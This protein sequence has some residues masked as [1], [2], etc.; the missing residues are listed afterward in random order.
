M[1]LLV[2]G[3]LLLLVGNLYVQSQAMQSRI[4]RE[5]SAH[6]KMPAEAR[7]TTLTPWDGL[8]IDGVTAPVTPAATIPSPEVSGDNTTAATAE[9][10]A[11][12]RLVQLKARSFRARLT[13]AAL[14]QRREIVVR[15][16][17]FDAP[18]LSWAQ[19]PDGRW[20]WP[21][22]DAQRLAVAQ[23]NQR[24][25]DLAEG[26]APGASTSAS[27]SPS[28]GSGSS[29]TPAATGSPGA[30]SGTTTAPATAATT[31]AEEPAP[32]AT[33]P[34]RRRTALKAA[35]VSVAIESF[36]V[37]HGT[38][39]FL[40]TRGEVYA[41]FSG[42][43]LDGQLDDPTGTAGH[44]RLW[45]GRSTLR[46]LPTLTKFES[47]FAYSSESLD[48]TEGRG[49][50]AGGVA[51]VEYH[52]RHADPGS[53]FRMRGRLEKIALKELSTEIPPA[54]PRF[55]AGQLDGEMEMS[56]L[57]NTA[58]DRTGKAQLR[59]VDAQ[60]QNL[61]LLQS[62]GD[63]LRIGELS[64]LKFKTAQ[65]DARLEGETLRI[66]PIV[67]AAGS[68]RLEARGTCGLTGNQTLDLQARLIIDRATSRGLSQFI[69]DI[70]TAVENSP[71]GARYIDFRI[72]GP[73]AN[74]RT[75][76]LD[77]AVKS[78]KPLQDLIQT[79]IGGSGG[80]KNKGGTGNPPA[81]SG[82]SGGRDRRGGNREP[83]AAPSASPPPPAAAG[84][85]PGAGSSPAA[86]NT[87][88]GAGRGGGN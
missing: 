67:L 4:R 24:I 15:E 76:L 54:A 77:R 7:K 13:L 82:S 25:A 11:A 72:A 52:L 32:P 58:A 42:V 69:D 85:R 2:A 64:Q 36:R 39:R 21:R 33:R 88:S 86:G 87:G 48:I 73:L 79:Y 56:G 80:K 50:L 49:D 83:A 47:A 68:L 74:P 27:P 63:Y 35:P 81:G 55:V 71:D 41:Q 9:P 62:L 26:R 16:I 14:W 23:E 45:F 8:R 31:P 37:R 19:T 20:R 66:D 28:S 34:A 3:G 40:D 60:L 78:A 18:D 43:N 1:V 65:I 75:D 22:G 70:F 6:L 51:H 53:P 44:G 5:L 30:E 29:G 17:L 38:A 59:I 10:D 61:P 12:A 84:G 57:S 46:E